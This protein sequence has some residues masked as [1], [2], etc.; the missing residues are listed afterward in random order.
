MSVTR[1][2]YTR[3]PQRFAFDVEQLT[4]DEETKSS[5]GSHNFLTCWR[6]ESL[7]PALIEAAERLGMP[8]CEELSPASEERIAPRLAKD[9]QTALASLQKNI[10]RQ[11]EESLLGLPTTSPTSAPLLNRLK[12]ERVT[13]SFTTPSV[14]RSMA[15]SIRTSGLSS[16][17]SNVSMR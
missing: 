1:H 10:A 16:T 15:I 8:L 5:D 2:E 4:P 11:L 17:I 9:V 3:F 7:S 13:S 14:A 6:R 12:H